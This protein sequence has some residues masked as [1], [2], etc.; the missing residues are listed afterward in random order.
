MPKH[1]AL[2][3]ESSHAAAGSHDA[4]SSLLRRVL[5]RSSFTCRERKG[6]RL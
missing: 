4:T 6:D 1:L 3:P 2:Y 5:I